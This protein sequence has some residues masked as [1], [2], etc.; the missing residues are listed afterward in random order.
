VA[1]ST[2]ELDPGLLG[3]GGNVDDVDPPDAV[4]PG[5]VV[6][7]AAVGAVADTVEELGVGEPGIDCERLGETTRRDAE[8]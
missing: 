4:L 1:D 6:A 8:Y 5:V 2:G 3:G 7:D